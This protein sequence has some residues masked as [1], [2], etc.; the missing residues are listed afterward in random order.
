M[1]NDIKF[2]KVFSAITQLV[3][4]YVA[5]GRFTEVMAKSVLEAMNG[6]VLHIAV[7]GKMNAGKSTFTNALIFKEPILPSGAEPTTVTL[8]EIVYTDDNNCDNKVDVELL[9][10]EDIESIKAN[11]QNEDPKISGIAQDLL[12]EIENIPG[13]YQQYLNKGVISIELDELIEFTS[14][15]GKFN[16]LAKKVTIYK[17]IPS[18]CGLRITDTPGFNDPINSR[19][20][21]TREALKD[22][23]IILFVH[24][25]LDKYDQDEISILLEQVEYTGVSMLVDVVNKMDANEDIDLDEW[26]SYVEKFERKKTEAIKQIPKDGVKELLKQAIT[27]YVSA[28]MAL[29]GY[30]MNRYN[31]KK[32]HGEDYNLSDDIKDFYIQYQLD[33]PELKDADAFVKYS[34]IAAIVQI[35]NKLSEDKNR[36][37]AKYPVQTLIGLL[38]SV[39]DSINEE[40]NKRKIELGILNTNTA[41]AKRRLDAINQTFRALGGKINSPVLATTL[42][43]CIRNTKHEIQRERDNISSSEFVPENY[44]NDR[45]FGTGPEKRNIS[46]YK[47]VLSDFDNKIREC[48]ESLKDN[49]KTKSEDHVRRHVT[50]G[51]SI[52]VTDSNERENLATLIIGLLMSEIS[53]GLPIAVNPDEPSDYLYGY[54]TQASIYKSDFIE[55]RKD[56][57]IEENYLKIFNSFV[58]NTICSNGLRDAIAD[59]IE[60]LKS[61]LKNALNF[62]PA[63]KE[64]D[65]RRL[66]QSIK[67][68][69]KEINDVKMDIKKLEENK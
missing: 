35:I 49:F 37:L 40:L 16:G 22:S 51:L 23:H 47:S 64:E 34:N 60:D 4:K 29:I 52:E 10:V 13:G 53:K 42:R 6:K 8:T 7:I 21:A 3:E 58:D 50:E 41:D 54:G 11:A 36:Y 5:S 55:R 18:L 15:N 57:T 32:A 26:P 45:M 27:S 17:H 56:S 66:K 67:D 31:S 30:E 61:S 68:L 14:S 20:E 65:G 59:Q 62:S 2:N 46:R 28:L 9:S 1:M 69:E 12:K 43:E 39:V 19:G 24:D 38:K 33:F 63:E 25:Y 48:L 44:E